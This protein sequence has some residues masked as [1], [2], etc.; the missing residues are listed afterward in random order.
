MGIIPNSKWGDCSQC[1]ATNVACVK[2]KKDLVCLTC[3]GRNK[4]EE[5]Q[6]RANK[7]TAARN[8]GFKL[9][10]T[11]IPGRATE[12]YGMAER[13]MLMHDLDYTH[14][15]LVRIMAADERGLA[16]CFTCPKIQH[17][18]M[19]QLSHFVKRANTLTRWDSRANRCCCKNCNENLDGNLKVFA[20]NLN[21]EQP[22]LAD[23]LNE[24]AREPYKWG[25]DE[26]KQLL[27]DLRAKLRIAEARFRS[28]T[29]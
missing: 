6:K 16:K 26:M 25:R 9:R 2:V 21:A 28:T 11:E 1:P 15:R 23:Q 22:G 7:R 4:A 13:Q 27:I 17:W 29:T 19:M 3:H 20:E 24:I 14:S 8:T 12:D 10:N 5:Q 18:S